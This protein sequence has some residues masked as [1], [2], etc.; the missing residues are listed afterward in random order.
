MIL[1]YLSAV[2][3]CALALSW[4][5]K[6][7]NLPGLIGMMITGVVMG[8]YALDLINPWIIGISADLRQFALMVI[9][10]RAGLALDIDTLIKVGKP[11]ILMS[12][13]P[14]GLEIGAMTL[15]A[16][17]FLPITHLEAAIMGTVLST[18]SPAIVVPRMLNMMKK[19]Q[20]AEKGIPQLVMAAT[21]VN[22]IFAVVLFTLL[23]W[24]EGSG[25][26]SA[27]ILRSAIL[28]LAIVVAG[29]AILRFC[30]D[31]AARLSKIFSKI[32]IPTEIML[33]VLVGAAINVSYVAGVSIAAIVLIAIALFFR[34][35]GVPLCLIGTRL[36]FRER[37]FCAIAYLPKAT[38]QAAIG[39]TALAV[40]MEAGHIILLVAVLAI[41]ITAPLG[42]L[43]I[44]FMRLRIFGYGI[45][46]KTICPEKPHLE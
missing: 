19:G 6:K 15:F 11:A 23:L 16:P 20:G 44:D 29:A 34:I 45:M 36:N 3:T 7:L 14:P 27:M 39:G 17:I 21:S 8:P 12:F 26:G 2:I 30:Y 24:V 33:F 46:E 13:I 1:L 41:L 32:W 38:V 31:F 43:A 22:G 37:V 25:G 40:G 28:P 35:C 4:L 10:A 42:A 18:V 9:L 5:M